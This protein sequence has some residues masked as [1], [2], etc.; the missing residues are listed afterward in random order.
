[1]AVCTILGALLFLSPTVYGRIHDKTLMNTFNFT[2]KNITF[3]VD[4]A[5][6]SWNPSDEISVILPHK[7]PKNTKTEKRELTEEKKEFNKN[8]ARVRVKIENLFAHLKVMRILKETIRNY[9]EG[10]KD[11]VMQTA[12]SLYNFR[13]GF[14]M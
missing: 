9:K 3:Y 13:N 14:K 6:L 4:L 2:Q 1:M 5:F 12:A 7:K 8:H 10:F 11:L